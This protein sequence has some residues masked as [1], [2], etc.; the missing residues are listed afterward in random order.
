MR[1]KIIFLAGM[2]FIV[3]SLYFCNDS[4]VDPSSP[5]YAASNIVLVSPTSGMIDTVIV[6][7][8][9]KQIGLIISY[10]LG[11]FIDSVYIDIYSDSSFQAG[12]APDSRLIIRFD[13]DGLRDTTFFTVRFTTD[14]IHR[15]VVRTFKRQGYVSLSM[16]TAHIVPLP[17][18]VGNHPPRFIPDA[19]RRVYYFQDG[20]LVS[21][22]V[23]ASDI[24]GDSLHFSYLLESTPLPRQNN[25]LLRDGFFRWQSESGDKGIYPVRFIV[26]DGYQDTFTITTVVIGDT[27]YN[28]PP[29]ITSTPPTVARTGTMYEYQPEAIDEESVTLHW[30]L[31]GNRPDGMHFDSISGRILWIPNE[32][33]V[34]GGPLSLKVTD[35]GFPPKS[36][37]QR[38]VIAVEGVNRPPA[39]I[40]RS[41][42]TDLGTPVEIMLF[43]SD[44]DPDDSVLTY[45]I[46]D[47]PRHGSATLNGTSTVL[48]TPS[49]GFR[50]V[51]TIRFIARD[52]VQSSDTATIKVYVASDNQKPVA[53]GQQVSTKEDIPLSLSLRTEDVE[54][55]PLRRIILKHPR[56]GT[57][58]VS[59]DTCLYIPHINYFGADTFTFIANDGL[60]D[61]DPA[62]VIVT[63]A[64]VNDTPVVMNMGVRTELNTPIMITLTVSDPDDSVF[65]FE[66]ISGPA[67]GTIDSS[68]LPA[69]EYRP[70][71]GFKGADTIMC[72]STDAQTC[73]SLPARI[74][75]LVG[76]ENVP[77]VAYSQL[78]TVAEDSAIVVTLQGSD[79]ELS[80]LTVN[81]AGQPRHGTLSG[82]ESL[83][84][85][86]PEGNFWGPDSFT[87][88]VSDG[89]LV[90][91]PATVRII[92]TSVNDLPVV[93]SHSITAGLNTPAMFFLTATDID[94]T[95]FSYRITMP[96]DHGTLDTSLLNSG[97]LR[98]T[99]ALD[100]RGGDTVKF[101]ARDPSG[102]ESQQANVI[103]TVGT[104]NQRPVANPQN[105]TIN[106]EETRTIFLTGSDLETSN[107]TFSI[108]GTPAHGQLE[109]AL[110]NIGY[111]PS[112]D[113]NGV[114][115]F[116]FTVSDGSL[117]SEAA[118]VLITILPI[119]D[120]PVAVPQLVAADLN[121]P[122]IVTLQADDVDGMKFTYQVT[123]GPRHGAM[124]TSDIRN[125]HIGYTPSLNYKGYDTIF[126]RA[127][128]EALLASQIVRIIIGIALEN[129]PPVAVAQ[130]VTLRED[131]PKSFTL[132]GRDLE[133]AA[134][135]FT[136]TEN[137]KHGSLE[138]T[139]PNIRYIPNHDFNGADTVR[140]TVS[141]G[142]LTSTAA[143][144]NFVVEPV[145]DAPVGNS[146]TTTAALNT[147]K[148]IALS[149][150]D[151][152][153]GQ[154]TYRITKM[155]AHGVLDTSEIKN[156]WVRYTPNNNF[157]GYDTVLFVVLDQMGWSSSTTMLIVGVALDN[158]RPVANS[159][160]VATSEDV[161]C[162]VTLSGTDPEGAALKYIVTD[163][164]NRG[165]LSGIDIGA[166]RTYQPNF[167]VNGADTFFYVTNDGIQ[168]SDQARVIIT[169][170]PVNDRP[171]ARASASPTSGSAPLT[172][173][174]D[175][176]GSTDPDYDAL[177]YA[178]TFGDGGGSTAAKISHSYTTAGSY[179]AKLK[180]SDGKGGS[181]S[182]T[183]TISVAA[184]RAPTAK[185]TV[186]PASG[187]APLTVTFNGSGSTD[188]DGDALTYTWHFDDGSNDT[189]RATV[190]HTYT[191]AGTY[192]AKLTVSDGKGGS[193]DTTVAISVAAQNE[194]PTIETDASADPSPVGGTTTALSVL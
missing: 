173:A 79:A 162:A 123:A 134:L 100:Y 53:F 52:A 163:W 118:R 103:I 27:T 8:V 43:A 65:S 25:N 116:F 129:Q 6:D 12:G 83:R 159:F 181:D 169:I 136:I 95:L 119:N 137:P 190:S 111:R 60:L 13:E 140:F 139:P 186:T 81:I 113:Y 110:P 16:A 87:F 28:S 93:Q 156:A 20:D 82:S 149:G 96:P 71:T 172:V 15:F 157:K 187:N 49:A 107:L 183:L 158:Q 104:V 75:I 19:P 44:P 90:S 62:T 154:L 35:D 102:G 88:T 91:E 105:V 178:W 37:S 7:S 142:S 10:V 108:T 18:I 97:L 57:I 145:N 167:N 3:S 132:T 56:H 54:A 193:D 76:I 155:P 176:S 84:L 48:Y 74:V 73:P 61:S 164:P 21:F 121:T 86:R 47:S 179:T 189:V 141:D 130:T 128:D 64:A 51:D 46:V 67:H 124:D 170:S 138:N 106:E 11:Y 39:A 194:A 144:V 9:G 2:T 152:D 17:V 77:P 72:R 80:P 98:Y 45:V 182:T 22:A 30:E 135:I 94:D 117:L 42:A 120:T 24:D 55:A 115:S 175:G 34:S 188:P 192:D 4:P 5:E 78:L 59:G 191:T 150:Y 32:G 143:I 153:G 126:F 99:P 127:L 109:G 122:I 165:G 174:F 66:I 168:N 114:D 177:T 133:K 125:G 161:S 185:A 50:G 146:V 160:N 148:L 70:R 26:S 29:V 68:G 41:V 184:N 1:E 147:T 40:S 180:V 85:Y 92:V 112:A 63:I 38:I 23:G 101:I 14:G 171:T 89:M 33:I 166:N 31:S 131:E 151:V 69:L 36:D 58:Q